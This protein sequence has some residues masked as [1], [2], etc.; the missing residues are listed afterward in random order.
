MSHLPRGW[1]SGHPSAQ[2]PLVRQLVAQPALLDASP[3]ALARDVS[4]A[5]GLSRTT[6]RRVVLRAREAVQ[7]ASST[8]HSAA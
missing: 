7:C 6:A 1:G 3:S 2:A 4:I 8:L 5:H